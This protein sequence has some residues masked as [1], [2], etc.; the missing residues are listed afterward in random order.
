MATDYTVDECTRC[1]ALV[2][3]RTQIV[4]GVG[5]GDSGVMFVGEAPGRDEDREGEPFVGSSGQVLTDKLG[6]VG[7]SRGEVRITNSVRCRPPENRD[8]RKAELGNCRGYL[9]EEIQRYDPNVICTLGRVA[10]TNI[11]GVDEAMRD[12]VGS[13]REVGIDGRAYRVVPC[14]HPAAMLYDRG[15]EEEI[16][17]VLGLVAEMARA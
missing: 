3:S 5:S 13:T 2:E 14:Y 15:K 16:D 8:P 11:L 7:L 1:D 10:T 12:L 17:R 6:D 9:L 4:N